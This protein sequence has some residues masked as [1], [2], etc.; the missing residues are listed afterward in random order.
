[1]VTSC[2]I[3][4]V[5]KWESILIEVYIDIW[6][7][8][9]FLKGYTLRGTKYRRGCYQINYNLRVN[10]VKIVQKLDIDPNLQD[11]KSPNKIGIGYKTRTLI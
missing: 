2:T 9:S 4:I 11:F 7:R 8:R 3:N 5:R 10:S 1:M 6:Y